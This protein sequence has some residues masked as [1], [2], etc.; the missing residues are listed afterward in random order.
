MLALS[1]RIQ[2]SGRGS[3]ELYYSLSANEGACEDAERGFN[4]QNPGIWGDGTVQSCIPFNMLAYSAQPSAEYNKLS[5]LALE[6]CTGS[7]A[8][9]WMKSAKEDAIVD[10][11]CWFRS[12]KAMFRQNRVS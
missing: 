6:A 5:R 1:Q 2:Y 10:E 8:A 9:Q 4:K 12:P 7:F 3:C 11:S